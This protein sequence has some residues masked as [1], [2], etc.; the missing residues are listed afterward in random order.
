MQ[1]NLSAARADRSPPRADDARRNPAT[2]NTERAR[3]A[4]QA[5]DPADFF[6]RLDRRR[7]RR[8]GWM[9]AVAIGVLAIVAAGGVIAYQTMLAPSAPP[10]PAQA[11]FITP[12]K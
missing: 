11:L 12:G 1:R 7:S 10:H 6:R 9:T 8:P 5:T 2:T 3:S 4:S